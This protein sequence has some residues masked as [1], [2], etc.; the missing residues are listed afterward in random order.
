MRKFSVWN[1][2]L[3]CDAGLKWANAAGK[4]ALV[5]LF[6]V[7]LLQTISLL[8][9]KKRQYLWKCGQVRSICADLAFF[10]PVLECNSTAS[11]FRWWAPLFSMSCRVPGAICLHSVPLA[12]RCLRSGGISVSLVVLMYLYDLK[13]NYAAAAEGTCPVQWWMAVTGKGGR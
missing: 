7:R 12:S 8:K 10:F 11:H 5:D 1:V 2:L 9:E 13:L 4:I 6:D 3:K